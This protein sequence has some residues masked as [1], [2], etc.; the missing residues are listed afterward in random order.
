MP[1]GV[2]S[3]NP[4]VFEY[5][6]YVSGETDASFAEN[7]GCSRRLVHFWRTGERKPTQANLGQIAEALDLSQSLLKMS[8]DDFSE[9]VKDVTNQEL[10]QRLMRDKLFDSFNKAIEGDSAEEWRH[11]LRVAVFLNEFHGVF[12]S[13]KH[14]TLDEAMGIQQIEADTSDDTEDDLD[15]EMN[16]DDDVSL[17]SDREF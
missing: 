10:R 5:F 1:R 7:I 17:Q 9:M 11:A 13:D 4:K 15:N 16:E 12:G 14:T 6:L 3:F 8:D 2:Q